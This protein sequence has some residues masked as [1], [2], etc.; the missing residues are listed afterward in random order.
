MSIEP[1]WGGVFRLQ[2]FVHRKPEVLPAEQSEAI[3]AAILGSRWLPD[4]DAF[5]LNPLLSQNGR[6]VAAHIDS[7]LESCGASIGNPLAGSP[8]T[9]S[10]TT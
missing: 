3:R 10:I 9:H 7:S 5:L 6:G 2:T 4:C 1:P 8:S